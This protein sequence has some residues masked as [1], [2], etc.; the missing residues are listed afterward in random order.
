MRTFKGSATTPDGPQQQPPPTNDD[1]NDSLT[2][3]SNGRG[4]GGLGSIDEATAA[5]SSTSSQSHQG[6]QNGACIGA[7][8][9]EGGEAQANEKGF[10]EGNGGG[11]HG[12][13]N[14]CP[15][16]PTSEDAQEIAP[17][18]VAS[19]RHRQETASSA[20]SSGRSISSN[21]GISGDS[22]A[23]TPTDG[24][25]DRA[26]SVG[27]MLHRHLHLDLH[28]DQT[29]S[30]A[31]MIDRGNKK[32]ATPAVAM[33][34]RSTGTAAGHGVHEQGS[35][36]KNAGSNSSSSGSITGRKTTNSSSS[37]TAMGEEHQHQQEKGSGAELSEVPVETIEAINLPKHVLTE[38]NCT[39]W[40]RQVRQPRTL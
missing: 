38:D 40:V 37:S 28:L 12:D 35:T 14:G 16:G 26:K 39:F 32:K 20:I 10:G 25:L 31:A 34:Q 23:P 18:A 21:P 24:L 33:Q 5:S 27:T 30:H 6:Q 1:I 17:M 13:T 2:D 29:K 7:E 11:A 4:V 36:K 19:D 8:A 9:R 22:G 3:E 15:G